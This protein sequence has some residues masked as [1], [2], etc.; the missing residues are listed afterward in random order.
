MP[1][2]APAESAEQQ[3]RAWDSIWRS[4]GILVAATLV[5]V[6]TALVVGMLALW[7]LAQAVLWTVRL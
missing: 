7:A 1:R 6:S 5:G 4:A 2:V 3:V